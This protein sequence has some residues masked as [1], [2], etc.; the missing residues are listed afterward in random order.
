MLSECATVLKRHPSV[1][2]LSPAE[3]ELKGGI[4]LDYLN[5]YPI[6]YWLQNLIGSHALP[7]WW[8]HFKNFHSVRA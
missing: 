7:S 5:N 8:W 4:N 3:K 2:F 1:T 6:Y